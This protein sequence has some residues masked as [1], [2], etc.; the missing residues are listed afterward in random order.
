MDKIEINGPINVVRLQG[1]VNGIQKVIYLFFDVHFDLNDETQCTNIFAKNIMNYFTDNFIDLNKSSRKYDFFLEIFPTDIGQIWGNSRQIYINDIVRLFK[2]GFIYSASKNKVLMSDIFKNVRLHYV[3]IRIFFEKTFYEGFNYIQDV[4][5]EKFSRTTQIHLDDLDYIISFVQDFKNHC[6]NIVDMIS[7]FNKKQNVSSINLLQT[8]QND[9]QKNIMYIFNKIF[10]KYNHPNIK[11]LISNDMKNLKNNIESLIKICQNVIDKFQKI[12][13]QIEGSINRLVKNSIT[14]KYNYDLA[15]EIIKEMIFNIDRDIFV[16]ADK[17]VDYFT[18]FMD[19]FFLR[20]FLDKDYVT[21]AIVYCGAQHA[22][23]YIDYLV[24]KL[25]FKITH[26]SYS[27]IKD[28][29][30]LH[31][32]IKKSNSFELMELFYPEK[33]SQCSDVTD[34]PEKFM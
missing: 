11:S 34:F 12:A 24:K 33:R 29:T 27:K 30:K 32:Q 7:S 23:F 19:M 5:I 26:V 25:N 31:A 16:L 18:E 2:K 6:E 10:T 20:R 9:T 17:F 3:D 14:N 22:C 13:R 28:F 4:I 15:D 21:N 1:S 8:K